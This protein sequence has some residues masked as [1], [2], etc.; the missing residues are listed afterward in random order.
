MDDLLAWAST[1]GVACGNI[2]FG[3]ATGRQVIAK[4]GL[5][6]GG[7]VLQVPQDLLMHPAAAFRDPG[8]GPAFNKLVEREGP[9]LDERFQLCLFLLMEK[10]RGASSFWAAYLA[11]LPQAYDDPF[12]WEEEDVKLLQGTALGW[13]VSFYRRRLACLSS[14]R[15]SLLASCTEGAGLT[16][17]GLAWAGTPEALLWVR[18]TVWSRSFNVRLKGHGD[19][20][21]LALVPLVDMLDHSPAFHVVW[22]TGPSS[23]EAFHFV[24]L[25]PVPQGGIVYNNYGHKS[26]GELL[27]GYGFVLQHNM[28]DF[29]HIGVGLTGGGGPPERQPDSST[30]GCSSAGSAPDHGGTA[31]VQRRI[32]L[33]C[34]GLSTDHFIKRTDPLPGDLV[35]TAAVSLLPDCYAAQLAAAAVHQVQEAVHLLLPVCPNDTLAAEAVPPL[36]RA[37]ASPG[38]GSPGGTPSDPILHE[39]GMRKLSPVHRSGRATDELEGG[40]TPSQAA[41]HGACEGLEGTVA[42]RCGELPSV[43][44]GGVP[45]SRLEGGHGDRWPPGPAPL[46]PGSRFEVP[47]EA[48][49]ARE[50]DWMADF[51]SRG[52]GFPCPP[53]V[54][55]QALALLKQQLKTKLGTMGGGLPEQ[56]FDQASSSGHH[57]AMALEYRAVQK[58]LAGAGIKSLSCAIAHTLETFSATLDRVNPPQ[59]PGAPCQDA[60]HVSYQGLLRDSGVEWTDVEETLPGIVQEDGG[61]PAGL[62]ASLGTGPAWPG[63]RL[64]LRVTRD[65]E[66][67]ALLASVPMDSPSVLTGRDAEDLVR[68]LIRH[69]VEDQAL[70]T[71]EGGTP[72]QSGP[73]GT[74]NAARATARWLMSNVAASPAVRMAASGSTADRGGSLLGRY[75]SMG[76]GAGRGPGS[77]GGS[78]SVCWEGSPRRGAPR[79]PGWAICLG[80]PSCGALLHR[81]ALGHGYCPYYRCAPRGPQRSSSRGLLGE[82]GWA[83]LQRFGG[84]KA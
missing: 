16:Q 77:C 28:A 36:A 10:A 33:A 6:A 18:S 72:P 73:Q 26:N 59:D 75:T 38:S 67:G 55:L 13:A 63:W 7:T 57:A 58:Q 46:P 31:A 53:G 40:G 19:R 50:R 48:V 11:V 17:E 66:E 70:G 74:L 68:C 1:K 20:K 14:W 65:V 62:A 25:T 8:Y 71:A 60:D 27:L 4:Q 83:G 9:L 21:T 24:T 12:W 51:A 5:A 34:L 45:L 52:P 79:L 44:V 39:T 41:P 43:D 69:A 15:D 84:G 42:G 23:T 54:L 80:S 49:L 35:S 29:F 30:A 78:C 56:D 3:G 2:A 64:G 76:A 32:L 81:N 47:G 22:H 37:T 82:Q 61:I